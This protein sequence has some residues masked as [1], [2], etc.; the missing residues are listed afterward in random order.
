MIAWTTLTIR[1]NAP[2]SPHIVNLLGTSTPGVPLLNWSVPDSIIYGTVLNSKQ[3]NATASFPGTFAY[4]PP[5]GAVL[6]AGSQ[7]LSVTFTPADTTDYIT[8]RAT[9]RVQVNRATLKITANNATKVFN[10]PNPPLG[11]TA[12]G[13]VNGEGMGVLNTIPVCA[14]TATTTSP[15]GGYPITCSGATAANYT[16]TYVPGLHICWPDDKREVHIDRAAWRILQ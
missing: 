9:V 14:T 16:I 6:G 1:D 13:F 4:S 15:V 12:S 2:G 10:T 8:V 11:S 3:L 5:L 7:T